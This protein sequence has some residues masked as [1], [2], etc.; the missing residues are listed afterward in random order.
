MVTQSG[1]LRAQQLDVGG[2]D[3]VQTEK[4]LFADCEKYSTS[5]RT[6]PAHQASEPIGRAG[7]DST[8][9]RRLKGASQRR[10][11]G[12]LS[13]HCPEDKEGHQSDADTQKERCR[14]G[15]I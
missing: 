15:Q 8:N 13:F 1:V 2:I 4:N 3:W 6:R 11:A 10:H 14:Q 5:S 9:D 12:E 7:C